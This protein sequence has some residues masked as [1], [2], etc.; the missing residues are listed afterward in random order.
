MGKKL[1]IA[2]SFHSFKFFHNANLYCNKHF[3]FLENENIEYK[4][5]SKMEKKVTFSNTVYF[6][7]IV[8]TQSISKC[9]I[10]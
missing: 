5:A 1:Q 4:V 2:L 9:C 7:N 3:E 10:V 6:F 8:F